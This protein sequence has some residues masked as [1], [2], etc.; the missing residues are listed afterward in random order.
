MDN[1]N[2]TIH[3]VLWKDFDD[4]AEFPSQTPLLAHYTSIDN[5]N[6]IVDGKELWFAN[7]LKMNDSEELIFGMNQGAVEFRK[8]ESLIKACGTEEV[9]TRLLGIFD[10]YFGHFDEN[11]VLDTYILCFSL[12]DK[13]DYDGV[14]S[15][16]RG[17]GSNGN[18][19]AFVIDT[20]NIEPNEGSP[21]IVSPVNYAT[22]KERTQWI[23]QKTDQLAEILVTQ[24]KTDEVLNA[25]AWHW[26]ER[27]K[28][29][30][31]FTKHKGFQEEKE[32]RFVYLNDRDTD[33]KFEP[34]FGCNV[35][36]KGVEPKLKLR[37]DQIP[38]TNPLTLEQLIDRII[39]GPTT[40]SEFS[41]RSVDRLL[42]LKGEDTLAE[43]IHASS[44]PYR[45]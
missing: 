41:K 39:L 30:S 4:E 20:K 15:M 9:F 44:I 16:W 43:K 42:K 13:K 33:K 40:A 27:L 28:V 32:W 37:I 29:F 7:P 5:F 25:I 11:H 34:M 35:S 17:Y 12:H 38:D 26:L 6:R 8:N 31:L 10:N 36:A 45:P 1:V 19:I 23:K 14:L 18:G 3:Q 2:E 24:E 21:I 22:T